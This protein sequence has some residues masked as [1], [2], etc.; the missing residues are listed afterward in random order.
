[1]YLKEDINLLKFLKKIDDCKGEV[2]LCT[3]EKDVLVLNSALSKYFFVYL[4]EKKELIHSAEIICENPE[5]EE[6]L[7][8]YLSERAGCK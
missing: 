8:E 5:D 1:M 4:A 7:M 2:R 6:E 3:P